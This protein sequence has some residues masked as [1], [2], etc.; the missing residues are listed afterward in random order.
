M[1]IKNFRGFLAESLGPDRLGAEL[2]ELTRLHELGLLTDEEYLEQSEPM[3]NEIGRRVRERQQDSVE[4]PLSTGWLQE[5]AQDPELGRYADLRTLVQYGLVD[6]HP[7]YS[8]LVL[9]IADRLKGNPDIDAELVYRDAMYGIK[10]P[11]IILRQKVTGRPIGSIDWLRI[12]RNH[13]PT[14]VTSSGKQEIWL[15]ISIDTGIVQE[16]EI[17]VKG[18]QDYTGFDDLAEPTEA[19]VDWLRLTLK[20]MIE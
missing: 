11:Q 14:I 10:K 18:L 1:Q 13:G 12:A 2:D 17:R 19:A 9:R 20:D 3:W 7:V 5:L 15:R 8:E 16:K 4:I 6:P